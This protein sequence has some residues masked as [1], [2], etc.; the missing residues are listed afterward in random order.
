VTVLLTPPPVVRVEVATAGALVRGPI[1]APVTIVEFSDFHCPYCKRV[2]PTLKQLLEKYPEKVRI[3][4]RD[5]PLDQLHPQ[6]RKASEAARC[7]LDQGKF[8]PF[9][10]AVY[11][12]PTN[13]SEATLRAAAEKS[14]AFETCVEDATHRDAVQKDVEEGKRAGVTGTPAFFINGRF[15][16]GAQSLEAFSTIVDDELARASEASS[17]AATR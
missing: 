15:V 7:A 4:Y 5:F 14:G 17:K 10:D 8:W 9:H 1:S 3:A 16:S 6:A 11:A 13:A 2:Q 12:G